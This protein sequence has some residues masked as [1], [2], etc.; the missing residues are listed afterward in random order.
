MI[1]NELLSAAERFQ[2]RITIQG[3]VDVDDMETA[4]QQFYDAYP[5]YFWV[6]NYRYST[7]GRQLIIQIEEFQECNSSKLK[8]MY[9][10][11]TASA[12]QII[13]QVPANA[14]DYDKAL[15]VHDYLV[16]HTVFEYQTEDGTEQEYKICHTAYGCIQNGSAVCEG[17]AR[18]YQYLM[19]L[20]SVPCGTCSGIAGGERH[21]WNYVCLDNDYYWLDLTWDDPSSIERPGVNGKS[22]AYFLLNDDMMNR[23]HTLSDENAF[24]PKCIETKL[25]YFIRNGLCLD[26]Y[27]LSEFDRLFSK[28][29]LE[30]M[31]SNEDAYQTAI[32][33]LFVEG[34]IWKTTQMKEQDAQITYSKKDDLLVIS[35]NLD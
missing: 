10:E 24:Q 5:E 16:D 12:K 33:K 15:F 35:I 31:F 9:E 27:S 18:A 22:H 14:S 7:N 2:Y 20:L 6:R 11:L 3:S 28:D 17:Y 34:D 23:S 21:A 8:E 1:Y 4:F 30:F 32:R 29:Q 13:S 19:K 25:N 26:K